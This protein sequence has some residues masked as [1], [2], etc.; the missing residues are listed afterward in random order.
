MVYLY[1]TGKLGLPAAITV[2]AEYLGSMCVER[3]AAGSNLAVDSNFFPSRIFSK[4]YNSVLQI[5]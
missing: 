2:V 4:S 5:N 1:K 3:K